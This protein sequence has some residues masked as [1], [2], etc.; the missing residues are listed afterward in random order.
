M[1]LPSELSTLPLKA[2]SLGSVRQRGAFIVQV[3]S[4]SAFF[5]VV[6]KKRSEIVIDPGTI[7]QGDG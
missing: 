2:G 4:L 7:W 1:R 6:V 5:C 3:R